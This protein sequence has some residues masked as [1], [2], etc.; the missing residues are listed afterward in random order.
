MNKIKY[1]LFSLVLFFALSFNVKANV[2]NSVNLDVYIN[3]DGS[4]TV[5][6]RWDVNLDNGTEMYHA[7]YNLGNSS[8]ELLSV[9]DDRGVNYTKKEWDIHESFE[10]KTNQINIDLMNFG[11]TL[12]NMNIFILDISVDDLFQLIKKGEEEIGDIC[13]LFHYSKSLYLKMKEIG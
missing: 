9:V 7:F 10:A 2:Y 4:A 6:E 3:K 5:T 11:I 12:I 1:L 13:C 8:I